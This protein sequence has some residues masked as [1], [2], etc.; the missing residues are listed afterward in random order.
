MRQ[1]ADGRRTERA[2]IV[3]AVLGPEDDGCLLVGIAQRPDARQEQRLAL[4]LG[5]E[6]LAERAGR[7]AGGEIEGGKRQGERVGL[8]ATG[9]GQLAVKH[10]SGKRGEERRRR[11]D[12]VEPNGLW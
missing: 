10:G 2:V 6:G 4:G 8:G 3:E 12:G 5:Q 1:R 9:R 7:A 11:R